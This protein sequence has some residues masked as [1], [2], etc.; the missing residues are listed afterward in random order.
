MTLKRQSFRFGPFRLDAIDQ[1]L[2]RDGKPLSLPPKAFDTLLCLVQ[3]CPHLVTREELI[4]TVWPNS[5]VEDGSLSV[6]ISLVR[7]ALGETE[8]GEVYIETVPR[9]GYRFRCEVIATQENGN[10]RP[11]EISGP[12][13]KEQLSSVG[14]QAVGFVDLEPASVSNSG[15]PRRMLP[16]APGT[17]EWNAGSAKFRRIAFGAL[18][19]LLLFTAWAVYSAISLSRGTLPFTSMKISRLTSGGE[20]SDAAVSPDGKYVAYFLRETEG[21]SLWIRQVAAP[22]TVRVAVPEAGEHFSLTFS[23]D[24]T[25]LYYVRKSQDGL[26]I[27]YRRPALGGD[28][29]KLLL[30]IRGPISFSPDGKQFAFI[31]MDSAHWEAALMIAQQD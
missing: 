29:A 19:A 20:V 6:S 25:Y 30:G 13:H 11:P 1:L 12:D 17:V 2:L 31:R 5:I 3:N 26:G 23:P 24:G 7:R 15:V 22:G 14:G 21:E 8:D 9:K 10:G 16:S 28:A 18:G 4:R 27:L